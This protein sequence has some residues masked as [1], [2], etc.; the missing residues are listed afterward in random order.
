MAADVQLLR[1]R[2]L[3]L[4]PELAEDQFLP[5]LLLLLSATEGFF[6]MANPQED[7]D[8]TA[9]SEGEYLPVYESAIGLDKAFGH[10]GFATRL[11]ELFQ[12]QKRLCKELGLYRYV[13]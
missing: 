4:M 13:E 1:Q 3:A 7:Y 5:P 2:V 6:F 12:H 8:W 11:S 9:I 10:K